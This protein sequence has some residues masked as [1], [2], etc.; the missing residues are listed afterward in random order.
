MSE[1]DGVF[2]VNGIIILALAVSLLYLA[3]AKKA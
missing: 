1:A 2:Y 3:R